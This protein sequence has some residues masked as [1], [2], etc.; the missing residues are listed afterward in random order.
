MAPIT[1]ALLNALCFEYNRDNGKKCLAKTMFPYLLLSKAMV[2]CVHADI[3]Q[4]P[5]SNNRGRIIGK[6]HF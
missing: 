2:E 3:F 6:W 1:K 5:F 4:T